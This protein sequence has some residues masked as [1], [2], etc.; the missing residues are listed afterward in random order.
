MTLG[1]AFGIRRFRSV[2]TLILCSALA[3]VPHCIVEA[4]DASKAERDEEERIEA[5]A[6]A[7]KK[8]GES[9]PYP[10]RQPSVEPPF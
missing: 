7:R 6:R 9:H 4:N 10:C 3:L 8:T 5:C 1:P 2:K